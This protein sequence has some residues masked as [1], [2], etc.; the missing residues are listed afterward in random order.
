[1]DDQTPTK[2]I[3]RAI[4]LT[5]QNID[6]SPSFSLGLT[7]NFGDIVGSIA[8]SLAVVDSIPDEQSEIRSKIKHD[9]TKV[10]EII[11]KK[12]VVKVIQSVH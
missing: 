2:R 5:G 10:Q 12:I 11:K 6:E 3:T 7:A 8:R 1:M 4:H 9:P